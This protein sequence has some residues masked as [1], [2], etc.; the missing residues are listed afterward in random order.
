MT[1][2]GNGFFSGGALLEIGI[3]QGG[4]A[5]QQSFEVDPTCCDTIRRNNP[6]REVVEGDLTQT[7]AKRTKPADF[8][9]FT[10]P[11]TKYSTI[12][13]IHGARTGDEMFLHALRLQVLKPT[14][15]YAIENVPGM[16]KFPVVM[17]ALTELPGYYVTAFC[18]VSAHLWL[19]QKRDRLIILA[20][21]RPFDWRPPEH[22]RPVTLAE[23]IEEDPEVEIPEYVYRRLR[24]QYRD[25]P[26][27]SD[28]AAG[29]IAP[30][31]VA[32][33]SKDVSTRL[34]RDKRFKAG[35]R[36]Y[37]VREYAR[38]QGVPDSYQFSGTPQQ[39]YR[40]IGNGVAVPVGR[41]IGQEFCRYFNHQAAA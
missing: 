28:P 11:C 21:R 40:Q 2:T 30:T 38:L 34:V 15:V 20:S 5:I 8:N 12:A 32:H 26:I 37:S 33:Y 10:F 6:G 41:W 4:C 29:D 35:V 31:C 1:P 36:P 3:E 27:I 17:E 14:E 18:P 39:Q 13:D 19:P 16:R 22:T 24:G 23:I 7:L 25:L 9:V